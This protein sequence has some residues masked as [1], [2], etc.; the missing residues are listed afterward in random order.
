[1]FGTRHIG[2]LF[3]F[4]LI[5]GPAVAQPPPVLPRPDAFAPANPFAAQPGLGPL[6]R[7]GLAPGSPGAPPFATRPGEYTPAYD[8]ATGQAVR[9]RAPRG[10][11][12]AVDPFAP[13]NGAATPTPSAATPQP[14]AATPAYGSSPALPGAPTP[15]PSTATP[16][17]RFGTGGAGSTDRYSYGRPG[18]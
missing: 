4:V 8:P 12:A 9:P 5:A 14:G 18:R 7:T 2:P 10:P 13:G 16:Y 3:A 11:Q 1:M 15:F 17:D 6:P